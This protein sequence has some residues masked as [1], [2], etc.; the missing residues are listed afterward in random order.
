MNPPDVPAIYS[1]T[2]EGATLQTWV[3]WQDP[4][5]GLPALLFERPCCCPMPPP[6]GVGDVWL[7]PL[8]CA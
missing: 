3:T 4:L 5:P 8:P 2:A 1:V 6:E 7:M